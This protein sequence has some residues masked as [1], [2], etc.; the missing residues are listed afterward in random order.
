M[1]TSFLLLEFEKRKE[2]SFETRNK[3]KF[4]LHATTI[5]TLEKIR[6]SVIENMQKLQFSNSAFGRIVV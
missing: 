1:K 4:I 5:R 6:S 2:L 3:F